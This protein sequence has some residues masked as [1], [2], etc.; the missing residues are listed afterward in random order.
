MSAVNSSN[1]AGI[2]NAPLD[3]VEK[4]G[5]ADATE[6]EYQPSE[7]EPTKTRTAVYQWLIVAG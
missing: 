2:I 7:L 5:E 1:K 4:Q 6:G 3:R